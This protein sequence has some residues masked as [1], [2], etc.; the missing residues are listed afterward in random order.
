MQLSQNFMLLSRDDKLIVS[1]VSGVV[2]P[3]IIHEPD[4]LIPSYFFKQNTVDD[5]A[6]QFVVHPCVNVW[7]TNVR[8]EDVKQ[9][10]N[11]LCMPDDALNYPL[12]VDLAHDFTAYYSAKTSEVDYKDKPL[13]DYPPA[14]FH[15]SD[16][17]SM[18]SIDMDYTQYDSHQYFWELHSEVSRPKSVSE[19]A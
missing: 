16:P 4:L 12:R 5:A 19:Y 6:E 7:L 1:Q 17:N 18:N 9:R 13:T 8:I 14:K 2:R 11:Q 15:V 3:I 10:I